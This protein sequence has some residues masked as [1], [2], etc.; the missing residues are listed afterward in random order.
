MIVKFF[1]L[2]FFTFTDTLSSTSEYI[3]IKYSKIE[4]NIGDKEEDRCKD[5]HV[6]VYE[7]NNRVNLGNKEE[8]RYR[9]IYRSELEK[10]EI[11]LP[12]LICKKQENFFT[13]KN[14]KN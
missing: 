11:Q 6:N 2:L 12:K 4:N 5:K 1:I 3:T 9:N 8:D 13:N 10:K 7:D 14:N